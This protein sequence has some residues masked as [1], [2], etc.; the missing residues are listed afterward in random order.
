MPEDMLRRG[1]PR[2]W[3]DPGSERYVRKV[4]QY[5]SEQMHK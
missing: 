2:R 4:K 1:G 3:H 5:L